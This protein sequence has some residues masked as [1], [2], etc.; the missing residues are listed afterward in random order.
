MD[1]L[2]QHYYNGAFGVPLSLPNRAFEPQDLTLWAKFDDMPNG[3]RRETLSNVRRQ[4][5]LQI[6]LFCPL[7]ENTDA[8]H[9]KAN[10]ILKYYGVEQSHSLDFNNRYADKTRYA[11][12]SRY[13]FYDDGGQLYV[14]SSYK[15]QGMPS[16][17]WF[18]LPIT[19]DYHIVKS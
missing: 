1:K 19:I 12:K 3:A 5:I 16:G 9:D 2:L 4:G 11:D 18:M 17:A 8:L 13:A 15:S 14:M 6:T 7:N 10:A